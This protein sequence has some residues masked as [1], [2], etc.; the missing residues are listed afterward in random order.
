LSDRRTIVFLTVDDF[1]LR[2]EWIGDVPA[3]SSKKIDVEQDFRIL[4]LFEE[5]GVVATLFIPGIIAEL[6]PDRVQNVASR[7]FEVAAHGY[8][9]ENFN[10]LEEKDRKRLTVNSVD[11]LEKCVG[12]KVLGWRSPGLHIDNGFYRTLKDTHVEWCSNVEL[13]LSLKHVPFMFRGKVELPISLIDLKMYSS[14]VSPARVCH[15]WLANLQKGHAVF[16]LV[17]HPWVQLQESK[18]LNH[19]RIFLD[20]AT[21]M[22]NVEFCTGS[23]IWDRFVSQHRSAY[24]TLLSSVSDLWKRLP[25]SY[26]NSLVKAQNMTPAQLDR[27]LGTLKV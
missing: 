8:K 14:S 17:V 1:L 9:H 22:D 19:L 21:T 26:R 27:K 12:K 11:V 18:R 6:F 3:I 2:N 10:L 23:E 4:D 16:T 5:F 24:G 7:G 15:K 20:R 25:K 13:P